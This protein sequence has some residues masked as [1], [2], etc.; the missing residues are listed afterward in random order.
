MVDERILG[1]IPKK[2]AASVPATKAPLASNDAPA[3][4]KGT[5]P[6]HVLKYKEGQDGKF[7]RITGLFESV[8]KG[9]EKYLKGTDK[10]NGITYVIMPN[11]YDSSKQG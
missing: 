9:G 3:F 7:V 2:N 4:A 1:M 8:T 11:T 10:E 5:K 6:S